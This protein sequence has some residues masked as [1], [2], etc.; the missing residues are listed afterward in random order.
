MSRILILVLILLGAAPGAPAQ[1]V[2]EYR[3][4]IQSFEGCSTTPY[5]LWGVW[6]VGVGHRLLAGER[7]TRLSKGQIDRQFKRDL[8][9]A[10]TIAWQLVPSFATHPV[11]I[12]IMIVALSYNLGYDGIRDFY[13]LRYAL[14][15]HD[16]RAA[17]RALSKSLWARQL[18]NRA[19]DYVAILNAAAL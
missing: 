12:R 1:T 11:Q 18:P 19:A 13:D 4:H 10:K 17:G 5:C 15:R 8:D 14:N 2:D 6:H 9:K 16:Y 3:Q 7:F